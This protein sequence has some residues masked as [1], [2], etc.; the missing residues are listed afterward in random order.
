MKVRRVV[1]AATLTLMCSFTSLAMAQAGV[2]QARG[3]IWI[4]V[5]TSAAALQSITV[6]APANGNMI[7][8][9]TGTVTY[10][11]SMGVQGDYCLEL[12]QTSGD[13]GGCIPAA[14]SD[15]ALRAYVAAAVPS[16]VPGFGAGEQY[17][18]VRVWPVTKGST[19]TFYINGL[20][21]GFNSVYLFQPSITAMFLPGTL[22]P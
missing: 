18:I 13:T 11:H 19:Y 22:V 20:Q 21:T 6:K 1:L 4:A 17:S 12:S 9:V 2:L 5:P 3:P 15:S 10:D 16:T 7:V 14:G 8:T